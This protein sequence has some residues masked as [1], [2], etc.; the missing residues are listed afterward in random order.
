MIR[1]YGPIKPITAVAVSGGVDSMAALSFL[2]NANPKITVIHFN[3][4]TEHGVLAQE[5]VEAV[6]EDWKL[7]L[8]LGLIS[9]SKPK[10]DAWEEYWRR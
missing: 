1:L 9:G 8:I 7:P 6:C 3:H 5:F 2:Q 10:D 4:G